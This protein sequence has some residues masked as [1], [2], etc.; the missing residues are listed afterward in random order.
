MNSLERLQGLEPIACPFC[1]SSGSRLVVDPDY[2]QCVDCGATGPEC[3]VRGKGHV[4]P[5]ASV[6]AWN[7]RK[8]PPDGGT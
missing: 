5:R 1:G 3:D 6:E 8:R 4:R 2:V 7:M